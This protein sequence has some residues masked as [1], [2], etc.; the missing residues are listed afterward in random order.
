MESSATSTESAPDVESGATRSFHVADL[1][2]PVVAQPLT[3]PLVV[4]G[5]TSSTVHRLLLG[6]GALLAINASLVFYAAGPTP[7][8]RLLWAMV[9]STLTLGVMYMFNDLYDAPADRRNPKKDPRL[10][11]LYLEYPHVWY[12]LVYGVNAL[13]VVLA[14]ATLGPE[15]AAAVLAVSLV[16]VVYS[17]VLKGVPVVDVAWCGLWGG[18][19]AAIVGGSPYL[20]V[21]VGLMTAMCHLFQALGDR[22]TD[23][24]NEITTTAVF[25]RPLSGVVLCVLSALI[26]AMVRVPLGT[27][28]GLTAFVPVGLFFALS[29][30]HR[31]W[32]LTKAYF[33][34]MWLVVLGQLRAV[35]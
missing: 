25:S 7:T 35:A 2:I 18:A 16:N 22:R 15:S 11:S 20:L 6:E 3:L 21:L 26:F 14:W 8:V 28:L 23:A 29:S 31:A 4:W 12:P 13:T 19:Y 10:V 1:A 30:S 24:V 9:V 34:A 32:L 17:T 5:A 33:A 27:P